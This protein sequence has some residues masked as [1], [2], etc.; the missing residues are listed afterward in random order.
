MKLL[1]LTLIF[2]SLLSISGHSQTLK[3][4]RETDGL[5]GNVRSVITERADVKKTIGKLVES[6]RRSESE[7]TYDKNGRRLT[8]KSYDYF[9][10][11]L[12]DSVVYGNVDGYKVSRY[13][14]VENANKITTVSKPIDQPAKASD[15]RYDYKFKYKYDKAGNMSEESWYQSNGKLWLR[16]VYDLKGNKKEELVYSADGSLNQKYT[17]TLNDV[18]NEIE[19]LVFD[20]ETNKLEGKET[21]EYLE[22]DAIGN[23]TKR[24][25]YEGDKE[26]KF[27]L[28]PRE[29]FY[30]KLIYY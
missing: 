22:L 25:T 19:M 24:I 30:R 12:F 23:W 16:Y 21:Y 28:K 11:N 15:P 27:T 18:G 10:G 5:K 17:Y 29:V 26:S 7:Y 4:D 6:N 14:K 8:W 13:E 9:S 2:G 1:V 20:V 3:T